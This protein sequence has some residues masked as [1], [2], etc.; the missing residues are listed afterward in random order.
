MAIKNCECGSKE[1]YVRESYAYKAEI[2]EEGNLTCGKA[3]GG[4][5]EIVCA[6]CDEQYDDSEFNEINF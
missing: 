5:S 1:F 4:I 6:K 3:N 2:D